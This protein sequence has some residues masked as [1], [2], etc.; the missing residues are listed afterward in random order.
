MAQ[1]RSDARSGWKK[2]KD[3]KYTKLYDIDCTEGRFDFVRIRH[4]QFALRRGETI[5]GIATMPLPAVGSSRLKSRIELP[6]SLPL[7]TRLFLALLVH[8]EDRDN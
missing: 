4:A 8:V 6:A 7:V 5:I 2:G 3:G 1:R